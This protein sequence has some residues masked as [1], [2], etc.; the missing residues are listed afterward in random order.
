MD[1]SAIVCYNCNETGHVKKDCPNVKSKSQASSVICYNCNKTGHIKRDCPDFKRGQGSDVTC[2][3]C[4]ETGHIKRNCPKLAAARTECGSS[5]RAPSLDRPEPPV[6]SKMPPSPSTTDT[7]PKCASLE[8][9]PSETSPH[10]PTDSK[11]PCN[12]SSSGDS[13]KKNEGQ[14][15]REERRGGERL[16]DKGDADERGKRPPL[17]PFVDTHCHLEY[18]FEKY[19]HRGSFSDFARSRHYPANFEGCIASFCD[20]AAFS[21]FGMWPELLSEENCRVWA[22]FG[23]HPHHA[24]HYN[25]KLEE[26]VLKCLEHERCV[27]Y[28]EIGL[29]N[30]PH[31]P[32]DPPSQREVLSRQLELGVSSGKPLL[33]HCRDA[34]EELLEVLTKHV[35]SDWRIHLHCYTGGQEM[36]LKFLER[37]PN[38]YLGVTG[39]VTHHGFSKL[40]GTVK[41]VSLQRLLIETDAPYCTPWNLP[42]DGRCEFSHPAHAYYVAK[43]IARLKGVEVA[44]VL[45]VVRENTKRLYGI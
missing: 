17:P 1:S 24:K 38:L 33:L 7:V 12:G 31:T 20:P 6:A 11:E 37:F 43:E 10:A 3:N 18:V 41:T 29:D 34:E 45:S 30:G 39:Y 13:T 19:K 9:S 40:H 36:A 42:R 23:I 32:S 22:A 4:N 14:R 2:Y 35:P 16:N 28:G 44:E 15:E 27:A 8:L 25:Q 26:K 5:P 21:S